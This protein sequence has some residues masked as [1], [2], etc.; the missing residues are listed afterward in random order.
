ML[1]L[2]VRGEEARSL[3]PMV[4]LIAIPNQ[5]SV[6]A[7]IIYDVR[8]YLYIRKHANNKKDQ[9]SGDNNSSNNSEQQRILAVSQLLNNH[10]SSNSPTKN[11]SGLSVVS[12]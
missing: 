3:S 1:E 5:L 11:P 9:Q 7:T 12:V 10:N 8:T 4:I 2:C 6:L